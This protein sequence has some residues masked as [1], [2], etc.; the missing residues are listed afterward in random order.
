MAD[1]ILVEGDSGTGK[2]TSWRN[3]PANESFI[4]RPNTKSFPFRGAKVN[5]TEFVPTTG[6][7]NVC[8]LADFSQIGSWLKAISDNLKHVKYILIEDLTHHMTNTTLGKAFLAQNSGNAAFARWN[9]FGADINDNLFKSTLGLRDDLFITVFHHTQIDDSGKR[10]F[11]TQGKLMENAIDP[12]S[13]FTYVFHTSI[14][15]SN[16]KREYMFITNNDGVHQAKTPMGC[17]ADLYIENDMMKVFDT[18]N[19]Y[20][21]GE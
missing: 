16:D 6:K 19:K 20:N 21:L 4:I 2:S 14:V 1:L 3:V 13:H 17:F 12:V 18:I 5:Y 8:T 15:A 9:K 10:V 7:G 11:K